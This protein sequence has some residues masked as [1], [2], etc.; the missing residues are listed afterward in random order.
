MLIGLLF[1]AIACAAVASVVVDADAAPRRVGSM[2]L[3]RCQTHPTLLCGRALVP[4]DWSRPRTSPRIAIHFEFQPAADHH[5]I[6]TVVAVEGGPGYS[7]TGS[8]STYRAMYGTTLAN[9][10]L[11]LVDNRG[12]GRSTPVECHSLQSL[13]VDAPAAAFARAAGACGR[14][15]D[16]RWRYR[17]GR[18]VHASDLFSTVPAASDLAFI[19]RALR[20]GPVD[21]YGDSYGTYF[22]QVFAEQHPSLIASVVLDSAYPVRGLDPWYR[23][24]IAGMPAAFDSVCAESAACRAHSRSAWGDI[25]RLAAR[26][27]RRPAIA[28]VPNQNG[29]EQRVTVTATGLVN[30]VNDAADDTQ[31]YQA[32]DAA[33]RALLDSRDAAPLA[34]LYAQRLVGDED[35]AGLPAGEYSSGL[36]LAVACTDYPQLFAM[37]DRVAARERQLRRAV[38][39][40]PTGTFSPFTTAQ[41]IAQ[42]PDTEAYTAC[43]D[44]PAPAAGARPAP[45][46]AARSLPR[47]TPVLILSGQLDLWTPAAGDAAVARQIGGRVQIVRFSDSTHVLADQGTACGDLAVRRFIARPKRP[48]RVACA[49]RM[50]PIDALGSFPERLSQQPP[51]TPRAAR[52]ATL[53]APSLVGRELAAAALATVGDALARYATTGL[54]S[55]RG[56]HG[57]TVTA[58]YN[59]SALRLHADQLIPGVRVSGTV[60]LGG[61]ASGLQAAA[62]LTATAAGVPTGHFRARWSMTGSPA[63]ASVSGTVGHA[64]IAGQ[65]PAP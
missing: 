45:A 54:A 15:L 43:L 52:D 47:A 12:T 27:D 38:R 13:S 62:N 11:L 49:A 10:N 55:D 19:V 58:G 18:W 17:D 56:L 26:L 23:S 51:L 53:K 3:A 2:R 46:L 28:R 61:T 65:M 32:L 35:Y 33:A 40:L 22:A 37:R 63:R 6:G 1:G 59:G 20:L 30:L 24:T 7:S 34:R 29:A 60:Q 42:D 8:L 21:L 41:W 57:G 36:Y 31:V 5:A 14:S 48:V 9:H 44:W 39:A 4:L 64:R 16:H 50:P 25:S